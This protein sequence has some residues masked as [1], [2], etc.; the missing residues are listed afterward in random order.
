M[1]SDNPNKRKRSSSS[2]SSIISSKRNNKFFTSIIVKDPNGDYKFSKGFIEL[3][4][5][6]SDIT[7]NKI[8][9]IIN[10]CYC[11]PHKGHFETWENACKDLNLDVLCIS[12][13]NNPYK[14]EVK[15]EIQPSY[16]SRHGIPLEFT[17]WV[18]SQWSKY[19]KNRDN[20]K[21]HIVFSTSNINRKIINNFKQLY[22]IQGDEGEGDYSS[23]AYQDSLRK[24]KREKK[25]DLDEP[26]ISYWGKPHNITNEKLNEHDNYPK[27]RISYK[28]YWRNTRKTSNPSDSPSAT[29]FSL[30]IKNIKKGQQNPSE[31]FKYLPKFL[32]E[33]EKKEYIKQII[34]NYYTDTAHK[35]CTIFYK[36][37]NWVD[38]E[39]KITCDKYNF[40]QTNPKGGMKLKTN[41]TRKTR[42]TRKT[43]KNHK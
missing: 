23:D 12:S 29:K 34:D 1:S 42:K 14:T 4:D 43:K 31:C 9:G 36:G 5:I 8:V 39:I 6:P 3:E 2:S 30:C 7:N 40:T 35:E 38:E 11:P 24:I 25:G 10:G 17:E 28:N 20:K 26:D 33:P 27:W 13:I 16:N 37:K 32:T 19:L 22:L 18:V 21:V 15:K 41:K